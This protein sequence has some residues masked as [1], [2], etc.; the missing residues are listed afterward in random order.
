MPLSRDHA[1]L[2]LLFQNRPTLAL[3]LL[4]RAFGLGAEAAEPAQIESVD[5]TE[6]MPAE[7]RADFVVR[8]LG[9]KKP[10]VVVV[11]VQ[12][13]R[14]A[15]KR[16]T[17]PAYVALLRARFRTDVRLLVVAPERAVAQWCRRP[18]TLRK[19][20]GVHADGALS[21]G[22]SSDYRSGGGPS[23]SRAL[24]PLGDGARWR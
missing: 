23:G 11:E 20:R 7:L 9:G 18:D 21:G 8:Y 17:W 5:V 2:L 10:L 4:H 1:A 16:F 13:K 24:S 14:D 6:A 15:T 22:S 3:E 12:R 19:W